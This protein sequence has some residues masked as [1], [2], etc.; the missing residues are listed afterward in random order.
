MSAINEIK[1]L[2]TKLAREI[3]EARQGRIR[4][5]DEV[6]EKAAT[7]RGLEST[8]EAKI[9]FLASLDVIQAEAAKVTEGQQIR[10]KPGRK[11][12]FERAGV[13][14]VVTAKLAPD[15]V[16]IRRKPGRKPNAEKAAA[17]K[18]DLTAKAAKSAARA[19]AK[20]ERI[21]ALK[22]KKAAAKEARRLAKE[23][24]RAAVAAK[25]KGRPGRKPGVKVAAKTEAKVTKVRRGSNANEG[26]REV[27]SGKRPP[28]KD[29]IQKVM[30]SRMMSI[31]DIVDA[32]KAKSWT[33]NSNDPRQYVAYL[34]SS[35]KDRFVRVK[36]AGRG[37]YRCVEAAPSTT[38]VEP[39]VKVAATQPAA[40]AAPVK[41]VKVDVEASQ[42][43]TDDLLSGIISSP[44]FGG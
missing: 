42:I 20:A 29:A 6:R 11:P 27:T 28:I 43:S 38:K 23:A 22:T 19:K 4:L 8:L 14:T 16:K 25:P 9:R 37:M 13:K 32:L 35:T 12:K 24:K 3:A 26:R 10:R 39:I 2:Q 36:G 15:E 30:G 44:V 40:E 33:P 7:L 21:A 5:A 18:A 41:E 34:L 31:D 17:R 1:S